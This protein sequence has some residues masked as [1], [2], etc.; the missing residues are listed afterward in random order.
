[1]KHNYSSSSS[2]EDMTV[3]EL[4]EA[5]IL[6]YKIDNMS[7]FES[8]SNNINA[9]KNGFKTYLQKELEIQDVKVNKNKITCT[10]GTEK[11]IFTVTKNDITFSVE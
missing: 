10:L 1:M 4:A 9:I 6:V 7:Q 5:A 2:S 8:S 11:I 3:S